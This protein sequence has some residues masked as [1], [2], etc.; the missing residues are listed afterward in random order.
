MDNAQIIAEELSLA[1][2]I[3]KKVLSLF[4]EGNTI[5][6]IARYRKEA[7]DS[8][9]EVD[10]RKIQERDVYL[11]E[12]L[13]RKETVTKTIT[14]QGKMTPALQNSIRECFSKNELEE[15]YLPFK[16]KK[17]TRATIARER[18]LEPL[19]LKILEMSDGFDP[20]DFAAEQMAA[21]KDIKSIDDAIAG[22]KDIISEIISENTDHRSVV[23]NY[24]HKEG[25]YVSKVKNEYK[26]KNTKYNMYYDYRNPVNSISSHNMLGLRRAENEGVISF[27]IEV[28]DEKILTKLRNNITGNKKNKCA[29]IVLE[30]IDDSFHRLMKI[31]VITRIRLENKEKADEEAIET[32]ATNLNNL[33]LTPPAGGCPIVGIDPGLRTGCKIVAL[34]NTGKLLDETVIYPTAPRND[35]EGSARVLYDW[36]RKYNIELVAIGNGTASRETDKFVHRTLDQEEAKGFKGKIKVVIVNESGASIYSASEVA[37]REFPDKDITVRGA[38]SIAR[39]LQDPLAE[40]VKIDPKSIGVGQ[41]QHDVHQKRLKKKLDDVVEHCV[42]YVGVDVNTASRELLSYIAGIS[43]SLAENIVNYRNQNGL[44]SSRDQFLKV[45]KLGPKSFEQCAGFLRIRNSVNQLDN[46]AVHPESYHIV[47]TIARNLQKKPSDIIGSEDLI[48]KLDP[49]SFISERAGLPTVTD[50]LEEL[51]KPGRD[52]RKRFVTAA[53]SDSISEIDDLKSGM[54]LEGCVTNVANFGAFV[55]IGVHQDGLV[56]ISEVANEYV[57]DIKGHVSVGDIVKVKVLD[58]DVERKRIPLSMKRIKK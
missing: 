15:I 34:D 26:D 21:F 3:V 36:F 10:L 9:D 51:K 39:R 14:D 23:Y 16:P 44:F 53:F 24:M 20:F 2:Q 32:F 27:T 38:V 43:S 58:V 19:A 5:P 40:L 50:I 12:L 48:K 13:Q 6:F 55:D 33:L 41:Y 54:V 1:K 31:S 17:R 7:T 46:S 22:A 57:R 37:A 8:L 28:S 52:P 56:H 47:D 11:D 49:H 30:A 45:N 4:S 25:Q 42:N 29:K 35:F 18:G